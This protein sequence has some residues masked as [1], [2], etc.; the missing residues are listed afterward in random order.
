MQL[1]LR[2]R[3]R[4]PEKKGLG[5][6]R[7]FCVNLRRWGRRKSPEIVAAEPYAGGWLIEIELSNPSEIDALKDAA[8][9]RDM[10]AGL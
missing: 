3:H 7:Y 4:S 1:R 9:Y 5:W 10:I 2:G 6:A 8:G